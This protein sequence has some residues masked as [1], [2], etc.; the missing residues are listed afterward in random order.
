V[1]QETVYFDSVLEL[2]VHLKKEKHDG[3]HSREHA[4][5]DIQSTVADRSEKHRSAP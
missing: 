2:F 3:I 1:G 4:S 5:R